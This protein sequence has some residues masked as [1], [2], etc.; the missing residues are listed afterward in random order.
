MKN[1]QI[2]GFVTTTLYIFLFFL[3]DLNSSLKGQTLEMPWFEMEDSTLL[4]DST[5]QQSN[6][7]NS[8]PQT[9]NSLEKANM[10]LLKADVYQEVGKTEK[11]KE[12]YKLALEIFEKLEDENK[13][14]EIQQ[15]LSQL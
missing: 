15:K 2:I 3:L 13:V 12:F 4:E 11:A 5:L 9:V 8:S 10:F 6:S 7:G 1:S 14:S